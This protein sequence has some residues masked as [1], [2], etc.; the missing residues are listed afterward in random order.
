M[1]IVLLVLANGGVWV[2]LKGGE[3]AG[4]C[5]YSVPKSGEGKLQEKNG[6]SRGRTS[7]QNK[8]DC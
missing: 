7:F 4:G 6:K 8:Q 3:Q 1:H 5:F 2:D